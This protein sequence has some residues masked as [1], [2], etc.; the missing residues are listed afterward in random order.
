MRNLHG[1]SDDFDCFRRQH[2][3]LAIEGRRNEL[4]KSLNRYF[5]WFVLVVLIIIKNKIV[6]TLSIWVIQNK[7]KS[8]NW[9][10]AILVVSVDSSN[11]LRWSVSVGRL[12]RVL[13]ASVASVAPPPPLRLFA[14]RISADRRR[15]M[16]KTL[17]A[18]NKVLAHSIKLLLLSENLHI[19]SA[20]TH[21]LAVE[22]KSWSHKKKEQSH[23]VAEARSS[24]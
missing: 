24:P 12:S 22:G 10:R 17:I 2:S 20:R 11:V 19:S 5:L 8:R 7:P 21:S 4:S 18:C 16:K 14:P 6:S 1:N 15:K 3:D 13:L 23:Q 9:S